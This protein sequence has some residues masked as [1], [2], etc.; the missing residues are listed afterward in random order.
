MACANGMQIGVFIS[1]PYREVDSYPP[2][3][4]VSA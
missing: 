4:A 3:A 2:S 1:L